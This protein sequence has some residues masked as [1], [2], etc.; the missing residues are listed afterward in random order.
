VATPLT[1]GAPGI[2]RIA[3]EPLRALTGVR[4]DV[5][6]FVGV[7]PRGPAREPYFDADWAATPCRPGQRVR[8]SVPVAVESWQAYVQAFGGF[9]GP[10]LLPYAVSAF[11]GNGG[12]R[13]WVLRIVHEYRHADGSVDATGNAAGTARGRCAGLA[14]SGG[15]QVWLAARNEGTWGNRLRAE[16]A[17][18]RQALAI[19]AGGVLPD[20]IRVPRGL[21]LVPGTTLRLAL[22]GGTAVIRR[23]AAIDETWSSGPARRETWARL[24]A[25]TAGAALGAELVEGELTT[26]DGVNPPEVLARIGLAADHPRWLARVLVEESALLLPADD[27]GRAP[28]DPLARWLDADLVIDAALAAA[29]TETFSFG[30]NRYPDIVPDDFFDADWVPGDEC[31]GDGVHA[32]VDL[33]DLSLLVAPD[34]Y[35]PGPLAPIEAIVDA[36]GLAGPEFAECVVPPP[37]PAQASAPEEVTGLRL[38]PVADLD[39][40]AGLQLQLVALAN[41]LQSWIALLDVP[42]G[43]SQRRIL[44][45]RAKFDSQYAAAYH[46]WL[47]IAPADDPRQVPV[48]VNPAALAAGIIARTE[49]RSGVAHGPA[50]AIATGAVSLDDAVSQARHDEL[51]QHAV[52]VY[53][54]ERDGIRLSAART[55]SL[56]AMWRQLSVR[57]I[58]TMIRRVLERQMQ[59]SV[60]EP[61]SS[62]LRAQLARMIEA[63]L[64]ELYRANAFTGATETQAFFVKCDDELNPQAV[65]D[66]GRLLA[67]VGIA[68]AE[69]MEFIVLNI[70]RSADAALAVEA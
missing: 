21:A 67:Q 37:P 36:H 45:W 8:R 6:A 43:L 29:A 50:N 2:Y 65:L 64:R 61:N 39:R 68:P 15:R 20:R 17:F 13:A 30:A 10:G 70:A 54:G 9:E 33:E 19:D 24:D 7:A 51:H 48:A 44:Y 34:L 69:P 22:A 55:L 31:P 41:Q 27:P 59:W 66:Q 18:V 1:L 26:G 58:V 47:R 3:D 62:E 46:P 53:L 28:G 16:L 63:Y 12:Q 52:N 60:F 11:F 38:D 40:I 23:V 56:D 5:C 32:L 4:M 49:Q 25:P 57:R 42:P 14:A 35:S